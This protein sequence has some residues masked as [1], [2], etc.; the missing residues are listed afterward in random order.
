MKKYSIQKTI[1]ALLCLFVLLSVFAACA[2]KDDPDPTASQTD[3]ADTSQNVTTAD[4]AETTEAQTPSQS[5]ENNASAEKTAFPGG[6]WENA[7]VVYAF[8]ADGSGTVTNKDGETDAP[9]NYEVSDS[10]NEF[11]LHLGDADNSE[12]VGYRYSGDALVLTFEDGKTV[13]LTRA[14]ETGSETGSL[15]GTWKSDEIIYTFNADG[16]G[17]TEDPET[18]MSS[19]FDYK[20]NNGTNAVTFYYNGPDSGEDAAFEL[21]GADTLVLTL[22]DG[23][24]YTLIRA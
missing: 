24:V 21:Q 6:A 4:P 3:I 22:A 23:T 1:G 20:I 14:A 7:E 10:K 13:T 18:G 9:F 2:K 15:V 5:T 12:T 16:V 17:A 19:A 8:N 11:T